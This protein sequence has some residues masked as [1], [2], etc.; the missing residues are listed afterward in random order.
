[1]VQ[2]VLNP[3]DET[4]VLQTVK[5]SESGACVLFAGTTR[6]WTDGRE[7][8]LL[9]YEAYQPMATKILE[10]LRATAMQQWPLSACAIVHRVG[11]IAIG[12]SSVVVAVSSPHRKDSFA[13]AS[14]IMDRIKVDVPI[15]KKEVWADGSEAWI[16][17]ERE[18]ETLPVARKCP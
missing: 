1:M 9:T 7:T 13:A 8:T 10:R 14:W 5:N 11:D 16:H 3:I 18:S 2:I 6:R 12:E 17:P 4:Q 15:W